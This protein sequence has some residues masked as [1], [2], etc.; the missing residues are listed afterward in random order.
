MKIKDVRCEIYLREQ[1][2]PFVQLQ[3]LEG[4]RRGS[5]SSVDKIPL[6]ILRVVTD[7]GIEGFAYDARYS[8]T[9][10]ISELDVSKIKQV[11]IDRDPF[12]RE[13]TWQILGHLHYYQGLQPGRISLG[14]L[15]AVDIALWD[16]AG[17]ALGQSIYKLLGAY[18]DKIKI[19]ASSHPLPIV[20]DYADEV[21][22]C[23]QQG[24]TAYKLHVRP[25]IAIEACRAARQAGGDD[26]TLM[27]DGGTGGNRER[28]LWIGKELEKLNYYWF[29]APVPDSDIEGLIKLREKLDIPICATENIPMG[30][31]NIPEYLLRR[32]CDIVRCDTRL[33]GGIT[34]CKKIADMCNAFGMQ[35]ELHSWAC[36][37]AN[38]H[39]ECAVKN[40]EFHEM[41]WPQER[42]G[43]KEYPI[44]DNEGYIHVPQK[45]G[46]GIEVDWEKLGKPIAS[47]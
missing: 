20:Q 9:R 15:S 36:N 41:S 6:S 33:H 21:A 12:D 35:C 38:L 3:P 26:M 4:R 10:E 27:L 39:V 45:P 19:Y 32:A 13:W 5:L 28:A 11:I 16:I 17:K 23:K 7:D 18:R 30:M 2:Q 22:S 8:I 40:C 25:E 29:E 44:L 1:L 42:Y 37:I 24:V 34:A 46:L 43:L 14:A 47:Y 31:F